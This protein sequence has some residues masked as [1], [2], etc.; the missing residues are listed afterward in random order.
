LGSSTTLE[1]R[2]VPGSLVGVRRTAPLTRRFDPMI[3]DPRGDGR[4]GSDVQSSD[5]RNE[6]AAMGSLRG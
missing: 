2:D 3:G 6:G 5:V 1:E 4:S